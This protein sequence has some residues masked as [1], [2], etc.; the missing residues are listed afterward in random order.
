MYLLPPV[1][2]TYRKLRKLLLVCNAL[3]SAFMLFKMGTGQR[4]TVL[5]LVV[6]VVV[7]GVWSTPVNDNIGL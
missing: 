2:F 5:V 3:F 6:S 1:G 7:L 4:H